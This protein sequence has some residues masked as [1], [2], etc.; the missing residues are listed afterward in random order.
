MFHDRGVYQV[1]HCGGQVQF[2]LQTSRQRVPI[3]VLIDPSDV[4]PEM[5]QQILDRL[6]RWLD[7]LDPPLRL[8][9]GETR[10]P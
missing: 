4:S 6:E 8:V 3:T 10:A 9:A 7:K 5:R 2:N 1:P